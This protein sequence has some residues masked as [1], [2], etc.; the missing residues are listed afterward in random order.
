MLLLLL[1]YTDELRNCI[2]LQV[3]DLRHNKLRDHIPTVVYE[4]V[5]LKTLY[6][7]FNKITEVS[8]A[9]GNLAVSDT[10]AHVPH[11]HTLPSLFPHMLTLPSLFPHMHTLPHNTHTY[12]HSSHTCTLFPH[13]LTLPTH[14]HSS[15]TCSPSPHF[16]HMHTLPSLFPIIPPFIIIFITLLESD[17]TNIERE[18]TQEPTTRDWSINTINCTGYIS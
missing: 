11:M 14:A 4:L 15:H 10:I 5:S 18:Q 13:M 2:S 3:L 1:L 17:I 7:K 16:P 9:I 8:P 12:P 6:L